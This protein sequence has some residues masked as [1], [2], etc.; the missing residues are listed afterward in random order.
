MDQVKPWQVV[1]IL[2]ALVALG[3]SV[4]LTLGGERSVNLTKQVMVVDVT[5]GDLYELSLPPPPKA[6]VYPV[7]NPETSK[8]A[9]MPV[10]KNASGDWA[11]YARDMGSLTLVEGEPKA[12]KDRRTGVVAVNNETPKKIK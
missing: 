3:T 10:S 5:T 1:L 8:H 9:L 6:I 2:A 7:V 12:I 11:I 4:Y